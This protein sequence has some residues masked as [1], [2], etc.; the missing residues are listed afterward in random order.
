MKTAKEEWTE[1][2][3]KNIDK[4]MMSGNR[5]KAYNTLKALTTT[6][7]HKSAVIEDSSG[8]I[9]TE[10]IPVLNRWTKYCSDLYNYEL[11]QDTSLLQSNQTPMQEVEK[12]TCAEVEEAVHSLKA[13]KSPGVDNILSELLK[14]GG[15]ATTIVLKAIHARRSGRQRNGRR[16]GRNYHRKAISSNVR[17]IAP[18]AQSAISARPCAETKAE[19]LLAEKQA[20]FRPRR[21]IVEKGLQ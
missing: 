12:S 7:K 18:S 20:G 11:Y 16:G 6:K 17:T 15:E 2:Q 8:N 10:S 9:L 3:C 5:K 13:G 4:G 19:E 14:N 1:E 21:S